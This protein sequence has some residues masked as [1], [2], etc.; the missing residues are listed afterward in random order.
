MDSNIF[1]L[2]D[3]DEEENGEIRKVYKKIIEDNCKSIQQKLRDV[4][5]EE[6]ED[7]NEKKVVKSKAIVGKKNREVRMSKEVSLRTQAKLDKRK[8]KMSLKAKSKNNY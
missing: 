6:E 7:K 3:E 2:L 8:K 1:K 4:E 5:M